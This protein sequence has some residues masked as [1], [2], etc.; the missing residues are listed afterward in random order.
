MD[1]KYFEMFRNLQFLIILKTIS[2]LS[3]QIVESNH[4]RS[5]KNK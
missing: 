5:Q 1:M 4:L 3:N 2:K